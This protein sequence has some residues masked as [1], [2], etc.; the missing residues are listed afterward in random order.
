MIS[1]EELK[2]F[3]LFKSLSDEE[4]EIVGEIAKK[5]QLR[6]D[7]RIFEEKSIA[8]HELKCGISDIMRRTTEV[9]KPS[10][11]AYFIFPMRRQSEFLKTAEE[12]GLELRR[13]REVRSRETDPP[14]LF[15]SFLT[16]KG[17]KPAAAPE[18]MPSL[19]LYGPDGEYSEEAQVIF[20]GRCHG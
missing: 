2:Q 19:L 5:E 11:R 16:L 15:L 4:L 20:S 14:N 18:M 8:K 17:Q 13:H 10:G 1:I 6:S 12:C 3:E 7:T 9:L